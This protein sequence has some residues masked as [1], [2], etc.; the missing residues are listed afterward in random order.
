MTLR[1]GNL[2]HSSADVIVVTGNATVRSDGCLVMGRGAAAE[3]KC[4]L[5]DCPGWF[6]SEIVSRRKFYDEASYPYGILQYVLDSK[7]QAEYQKRW[8]SVPPSVLGLFQVKRRWQDDADVELIEYS[9]KAMTAVVWTDW[10]GKKVAMNFPG[11]G[12][13]RLSREDVLPLVERLPT[14]V[15]VWERG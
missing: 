12:N 11:I 7:Q 1:T 14:G 2:W 8:R 3:A 5:P 9:V 10:Q 13:G 6:G 15:E 4:R